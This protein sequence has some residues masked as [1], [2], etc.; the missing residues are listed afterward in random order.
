MKKFLIILIVFIVAL[1]A[2]LNAEE[3]TLFGDDFKSGF[4]GAP[5]F[6]IT[7]VNSELAVL[8]GG[9]GAWIVNKT[10]SLGMGG[11]WLAEDV[12][13]LSMT[14][15]GLE[16]GYVLFPDRLLHPAFTA[17]F[18][19]G[20]ASLGSSNDVFFAIEP[21]VNL[22]VNVTTWFKANIGASYRFVMGVDGLTGINNRDLGGPAVG[23]ILK[24]GFF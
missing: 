24:F 19:T 13:N 12:G 17:L 10:F 21:N 4:Y 23:I 5:A 14:Y 9:H 18:A 11:Y 1:P 7:F 15:G 20:N 3:K 16:L 22:E 8:L 2:L 6:K